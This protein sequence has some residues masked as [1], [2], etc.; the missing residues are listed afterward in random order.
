MALISIAALGL[1]VLPSEAIDGIIAFSRS[2]LARFDWLVLALSTACVLLCAVGCV[3]P[4][5]RMRLGGPDARPD[6]SFASWVSMLFAAGMGAG[7][8]FWGAAEPLIFVNGFTRYGPGLEGGVTGEALETTYIGARALVMFHWALH[9]W[10]IYAVSAL[11]IGLLAGRRRLPLL[12]SAGIVG[13]PKQA[14]LPIDTIALLCVVFGIT[15]SLGQGVIQVQAGMTEVFDL[16]QAESLPGSYLIIVVLAVLFTASA[17]G[18]IQHGIKPLSN[19]NSVLCT[20]IFLVFAVSFGLWETLVSL[21]L[22][23]SA[24]AR[25]FLTL[26]FTLPGASAALEGAREW[27][28]AWSM[29]YLLWW[30]AWTPFVGVFIARISHGR[31]VRS[32]V[33]AVVL[34]PSIVTALWFAAVGGLALHVQENLPAGMGVSELADTA[35][36]TFRV[37]AAQEYGWWFGAAIIISVAIFIITS[38]D[39]GS[40]VLAEFSTRK[41]GDPP[42]MVRASWGLLLALLTAFVVSSDQGQ[43]ATRSFAVVGAIPLMVILSL[44]WGSILWAFLNRG[45]AQGVPAAQLTQED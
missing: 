17:L 11:A 18:G 10:A 39:S 2:F 5:S 20:G 9:P 22:F 40:F 12:P 6:F 1:I 16:Q 42:Q 24:Y 36:A 15:A 44:Q 4:W 27:S 37:A 3:G 21:W 34:V 23:L 8:L 35:Y 26:S 29:T 41:I 7:L 14:A 13:L 33:L 45:P 25:E 43:H 30:V 19:L 28:R 38:A 31:T 32:F